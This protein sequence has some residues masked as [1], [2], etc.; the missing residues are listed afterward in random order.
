MADK[1]QRIRCRLYSE[2]IVTWDDPR[3]LIIEIILKER[4]YKKT[5]ERMI[6]MKINKDVIV[7][8]R[9]TI[10]YD[11]QSIIRVF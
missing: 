11:F 8:P 7:Y 1:F 6:H 2:G 9:K 4:S 5:Q 3:L 10:S